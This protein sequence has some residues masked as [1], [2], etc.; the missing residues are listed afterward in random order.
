MKGKLIKAA[1]WI[2]KSLMVET[3]V[4]QATYERRLAACE[5]CELLDSLRRCTDC[6]CFVDSKALADT[7]RDPLTLKI[8]HAYCPLAK[9]EPERDNE[10]INYYKQLNISKND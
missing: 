7:Y 4:D 1:A 9:W 8:K 10:L 3:R 6:G 5:G 2:T